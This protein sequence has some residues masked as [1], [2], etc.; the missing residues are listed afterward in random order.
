M[1]A[2]YEA[3]LEAEARFTRAVDKILPGLVH[4]SNGARGLHEYGVTA[5]EQDE[6]RQHHCAEMAEY[7]ADF[8]AILDLRGEVSAMLVVL[9]REQETEA[10]GEN[11]GRGEE[12]WADVEQAVG[13]G[14]PS[15]LLGTSTRSLRRSLARLRQASEEGR[16][17]Q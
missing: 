15:I 9:L 5:A 4:F 7:A 8:P 16:D 12:Y 1:I 6:R 2:R 10:A 11:A 3:Q 14:A 17:E 13:R